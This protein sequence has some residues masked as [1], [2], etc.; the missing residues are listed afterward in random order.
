V[1]GMMT[2]WRT[3][4]YRKEVRESEGKDMKIVIG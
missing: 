1:G 4:S 2:G 3:K